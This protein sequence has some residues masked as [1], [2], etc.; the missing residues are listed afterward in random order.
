LTR[1]TREAN[2]RSKGQ[3]QG[4]WEKH[5]NVNIVFRAHIRQSGS[6]YVKPR[7]KWYSANSTHRPIVEYIASAEM[8]HFVLICISDY[9]R[10]SWVTA[11]A[12]SCTYSFIPL[13]PC[14]HLCECV[15]NTKTQLIGLL[16]YLYMFH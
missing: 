8:T 2:L 3:S 15:L 4:H 1:V 6:I 13:R 5:E 14:E 11:A 12:W 9:S 10:G 16:L 7:P